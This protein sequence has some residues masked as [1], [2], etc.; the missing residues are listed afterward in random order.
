MARAPAVAV[1]AGL[2]GSPGSLAPSSPDAP[3]GW[4]SSVPG[5]GRDDGAGQGG[6]RD[7]AARRGV[8]REGVGREGV[9]R[10]G[11]SLRVPFDRPVTDGG[12]GWFYLDGVSDDGA[13]A[14]VLIA[15]LGNVFSPRRAR[16]RAAG[17]PARALDFSAVNV[18]VH[19]PRRSRWAMTERGAQAVVRSRDELRIGAS[20]L[21]WEGD[22][23][24][25]H[26]NERSAPWGARVA[27]TL[28]FRPEICASAAVTLDAAG[29]H[30]WYPQAPFGR[31]EVDF[32]EPALR[33]RGHGYFD[34]NFGVEPLEDA[35]ASWTWSRFATGDAVSIAYDVSLRDG[36]AHGRG[37]QISRLGEASPL[38]PGPTKQLAPTRFRLARPVRSEAGARVALVRTLE[39]GPF[40]ARSLV[41]TSLRGRPALGMHET[42]SLDRFGAPWVRFLVPFRM[43]VEGA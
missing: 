26:V 16:A 1:G 4:R 40:Y 27:G 29:R 37:V 14:V 33:F 17:R 31:I 6:L 21:G 20:G 7:G 34:A 24:V 35:F 13:S 42:V 32:R 15:L 28:R 10:E 11:A 2:D 41:A 18:A 9:E 38:E 25:A 5:P 3:A 22:A 30:L 39:D 19:G 23:L 12:Y 36:T 8:G 43:R